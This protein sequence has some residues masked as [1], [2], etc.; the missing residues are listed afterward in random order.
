MIPSIQTTS[1]HV[2]DMFLYYA[3]AD[4]FET[5]FYFFV[6]LDFLNNIQYLVN[7]LPL[8]AQVPQSAS[9]KATIL[10][11]ESAV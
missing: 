10:T 8:Y 9:Q 7:D 5:V 3:Y 6:F 11:L 2:C 4:D 1:L